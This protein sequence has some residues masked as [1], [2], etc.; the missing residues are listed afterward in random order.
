MARALL[1]G[2]KRSTKLG[3]RARSSTA[4]GWAGVPSTLCQKERSMEGPI[5]RTVRQVLK[6]RTPELYRSLASSGELDQFVYISAVEV[7][8]EVQGL[9]KQENW[10]YLPHLE[11]VQR[12][13]AARMH[14]TESILGDLERKH[15]HH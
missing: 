6:E 13:N 9:R 4:T 2:T 8:R 14:L 11:L 12:L 15:A 10:D 5:E 1:H 7:N 3:R